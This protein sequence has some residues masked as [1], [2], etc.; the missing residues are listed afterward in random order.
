MLSRCL[1]EAM[2][3]MLFT[4]RSGCG[5]GPQIEEESVGTMTSLTLAMEHPAEQESSGG[6]E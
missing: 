4:A 1:Q 2:L 3:L 6:L 5:K